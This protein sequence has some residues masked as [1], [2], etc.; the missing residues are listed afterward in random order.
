VKKSGDAE[1]RLAAPLNGAH[2]ERL[3]TIG[4]ATAGVTHEINNCLASI[5]T[6]VEH[7]KDEVGHLLEMI[8]RFKVF[9]GGFARDGGAEYPGHAQAVALQRRLADL[10]RALEDARDGAER[11]RDVV[12]S[13]RTLASAPPAGRGPVNLHAALDSA[14]LLA[15]SD[16]AFRARLVTDFRDVPVVDASETELVQVFVN[17]LLNAAQAIEH[18]DVGDNEIRVTTRVSAA[19]LAVIE[20]SDTGGGISEEHASQLFEPFFTT[21]SASGG[22]GLGLAICREIVRGLGGDI[23]ARPRPSRGATFRVRLPP[24]AAPLRSGAT[25][26]FEPASRRR[27]KLLVVDDDRPVLSALRRVLATEHEVVTARGG[28]EALARI[29]A[30]ERFDAVVCDLIMPGVSGMELHEELTKRAPEL[31]ERM[32]FL[33]GGPLVR[34]AAAFLDRVPNPRHDK[35]FGVA[36]LRAAVRR[37]VR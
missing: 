36:E 5:L 4:I 30:G 14:I 15:R 11:A 13:V 10:A 33:I 35:P 1:S 7:G 25:P 17:L 6:N 23:D 24:R 9:A 21:K 19:G 31:A 16:I 26:P 22:T 37:L 18:G 28:A 32:L 12:R 3:A 34:R 2:R 29:D 20:V 8:A 27:P